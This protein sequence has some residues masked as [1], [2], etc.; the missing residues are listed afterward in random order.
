M[1]SVNY[2]VC[3]LSLQPRRSFVK[4]ATRILT[5]TSAAALTIRPTTMGK[6]L[7]WCLYIFVC[8]HSRRATTHLE[9]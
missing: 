5:L 4:Q 9:E 1:S 3:R 2:L 8:L 6:Y 7:S